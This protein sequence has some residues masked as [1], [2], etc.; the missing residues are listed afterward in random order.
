MI[1]ELHALQWCNQLYCA[2]G[3]WDYPLCIVAV[4][5]PT[6][7]LVVCKLQHYDVIGIKCAW[8]LSQDNMKLPKIL[9][10]LSRTCVLTQSEFL[11]YNVYY[12]D[13]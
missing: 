8:D 4:Y 6:I 10:P 5:F 12:W 2:H 7:L 9:L 1:V 13:D 11:H 3:N